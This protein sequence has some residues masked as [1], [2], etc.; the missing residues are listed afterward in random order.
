MDG[1]CTKWGCE[2]TREAYWKPS[3]SWDLITLKQG[4]TPSH[5]QCQDN[6]G[7]RCNSLVL[8]FTASG[9][10]ASWDGPKSWGLRLYV[11]GHDPVT[12]FSLNRWVANL[13]T[14]SIGPNTVL[15]DQ[16]PPSIPG[17]AQPPVQ[18]KSTQTPGGV[19]VPVSVPS[20]SSVVGSDAP[21]TQPPGTGDW[22]INLVTGAYLAL[23]Y[24]DPSRTQECCLCF[25]SSPP[26]YKGV[27]V[28]G[29]YTNQTIVPD[30][31]TAVPSHKLT[32]PEVSGQGLC[33]RNI[34]SIHQVL[35]KAT[36]KIHAGN[37]YLAAPTDNYW[38]CNTGLTPCISATVLDQSS[39]YCVLVEIWPKVTYHEPEYIYSHF[40]KQT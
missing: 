38:A 16:K 20:S 35:C 21:T 36:K 31:C 4:V 29:N 19:S 1:Y 7:G 8:Q 26:Y 10:K 25:V 37:Y 22:L 13:A 5:E 9:K 39:D 11:L 40:E 3:S 12:M 6:K 27:A 28:L 34:P 17:P 2:T 24:S 18:P 15:K 32:L 30:S 14:Q 33:L 23:N